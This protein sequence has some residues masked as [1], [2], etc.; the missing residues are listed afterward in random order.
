[1]IT[2]DMIKIEVEKNYNDEITIR[3]HI[4]LVVEI[5]ASP[6]TY[7]SMKQIKVDIIELKTE[8]V[9]KVMLDNIYKEKNEEIMK[10]NI[11]NN[12]LKEVL[13]EFNH[14]LY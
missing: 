13:E 5:H 7:E 2:E 11:E 9:K 8:E 3:G 10:L 1:M 4:H 6:I 14:Y 12:H